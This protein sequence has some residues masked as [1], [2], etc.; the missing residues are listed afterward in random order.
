MDNAIM[1][2]DQRIQV[3]INQS[4]DAYYTEYLTDLRMKLH[5]GVISVG[6]ARSEIDRTF[7]VYQRRM[8]LYEQQVQNTQ[9]QNTQMYTA[10][11]TTG[12]SIVKKEKKNVE[13]VVG[14]GV[15]SV[16]GALFLLVSF[17]MLGMT[18]MNGM[19]KGLCLYVIALAVL[20]FSE[21]VISKK[22]PKL[23]IGI[24]GMAI[25][26]FYLA[27]VLN[28][29]YL[30]NINE[31]T[32]IIVS[33][34][35][36][37]AAILISRK[38]DSGIIKIISFEGFYVSLILMTYTIFGRN[39]IVAD[40]S[41]FDITI[42]FMVLSAI[43]FIVN[44]MTIYLPVKK[45]QNAIHITHLVTNSLFVII[46]SLLVQRD[47]DNWYFMLFGS[48]MF[49]LQGFI[50]I[51]MKKWSGV[52]IATQAV[53][54]LTIFFESISIREQWQIHSVMGILLAACILQ[55][56]LL[57]KT[58][59]IWIPYWLFFSM[60][61]LVYGL[62]TRTESGP[63]YGFIRLGVLITL[64]LISKGLSG[65]SILKGSD[66]IFTFFTAVA[67]IHSFT[68]PDLTF[69]LCY[70]GAFLISLVLVKKW[71]SLN[72]EIVILLFESFILI[73]FHDNLTLAVLTGI[74]FIGVISFNYISFFRDN[75]TRIYNYINLSLM[76]CLYLGLVFQKDTMTFF[77][78]L[79]LGI[80]YALLIFREKFE[81]NF[82]FRNLI[83]VLFL[84]YMTF[85]C[86]IQIPVIKSIILMIIAI[87]TVV[88]G[89]AVKSKITRIWGLGLS[90]AVCF[91][92]ALFDFAKSP[93]TEKMV[94][95]MVIG[96]IAL[97][98]SGIYIALEKKID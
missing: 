65:I 81:M 39:G 21:I 11:N 41:K 31:V 63:S 87:A 36:S 2:I 74:L 84:C 90:L 77:I 7:Y 57:R 54:L 45:M 97:A 95:F 48:M 4:K 12:T 14:A 78:M 13:F 83:T 20:L 26:G 51:K 5:Q 93:S 98:T 56:L 27:T 18:Y 72:H 61:Y 96:I 8:Q 69:A 58:Y 42:R 75:Q 3:L 94:L 66:L 49:L 60:G 6:Y 34:A 37:F 24:T 22:M 89:F 62:C 91:K 79:L 19:I 71:K 43:I 28:Y 44:I 53:I 9:M 55:Y 86:N 40:M 52:Y 16:V 23:G 35:I 64:F 59:L 80:T 92:L 10:W 70:L 88:T 29:I 17:V 73:N 25:C 46:F 30:G 38:K 15:L 32:A 85:V 76:V 68:Q 82:K 33:V 50:Y 1:E 67:A 47:V